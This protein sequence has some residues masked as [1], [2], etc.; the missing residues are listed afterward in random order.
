VRL[1]EETAAADD[2]IALNRT[3]VVAAIVTTLAEV[4]P[5]SGRLEDLSKQ[6]AGGALMHN[7]GCSWGEALQGG[8]KGSVA[9]SARAVVA[10]KKAAKVLRDGAALGETADFGIAWLRGQ[11]LDLTETD[12]QLRR[13]VEGGDVDALF[14]GHFSAA[15]AARALMASEDLSLNEAAL[16][17]ALQHV[18]SGQQQ[19]VWK[20][21]DNSRPIWMTYQGASVIRDYLL[22]GL[23]WPP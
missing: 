11:D 17:R 5:T 13:P 19:G 18:V 3:A 9:H 2:P 14:I 23:A 10:L 4:N 6:L 20:W 12:E 7:G 16:R 15:W 8:P 22:R 21:H 1:L